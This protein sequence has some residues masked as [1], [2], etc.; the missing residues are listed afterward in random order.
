MFE[1]EGMIAS[2]EKA[3]AKCRRN[4]AAQ[5]DLR[6]ALANGRAFSRLLGQLLGGAR[7][8]VDRELNGELEGGFGLEQDQGTGPEENGGI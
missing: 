7:V 2:L 6:Q 3:L 8:F 5:R 4:K 1:G